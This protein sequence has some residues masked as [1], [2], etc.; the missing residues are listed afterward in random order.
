MLLKITMFDHSSD[1]TGGP[2]DS[3][4]DTVL[5]VDPVDAA[6]V[7]ALPDGH[8]YSW[9]DGP[10]FDRMTGTVVDKPTFKVRP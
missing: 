8:H 1:V 7:V 10:S 2:L 3:V 5:W 4:Y 6:A 9:V